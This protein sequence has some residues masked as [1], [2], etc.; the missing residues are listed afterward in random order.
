[1][2]HEER[3]ALPQGAYSLIPDAASVMLL[4]IHFKAHCWQAQRRE[5]QIPSN[6]PSSW[7]SEL[8]LL[9]PGECEHM[10]FSMYGVW[11]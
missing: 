1:M 11:K 6:I 2:L 5:S 4:G 9:P 7:T 8:K 10:T 3:H